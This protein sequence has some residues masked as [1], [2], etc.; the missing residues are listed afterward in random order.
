MPHALARFLIAHPRGLALL[1]FG[2]VLL[3]VLG[4][5][6][7]RIDASSDALVVETD[8]ALA[9]WRAMNTRYGSGEFLVVTYEPNTPL[10]ETP[11]LSTLATL[12]AALR[13][14]DGVEEVQSL[15]DV[16]LLKSPPVPL[17]ALSEGVR[18]LRDPST[19]RALARKELL[20]SPLFR[21]LL[22]SPDGQTT[23]LQVTLSPDDTFDALLGE[24]QRWLLEAESRRLTPEEDA[25]RRAAV[26]ALDAYK[27]QAAARQA[28]LVAAV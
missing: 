3:A 19:D 16:P 13:A 18:T 7:F 26:A 23:A 22:L 15:L 21:N 9:I 24:R 6:Q 28:A 4:A 8:P 2:A 11:A 10:F 25:A 17:D 20:E 5:Q 14:V 1:L 12:V 27:P